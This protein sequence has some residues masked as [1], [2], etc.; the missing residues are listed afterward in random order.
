M[1]YF[2]HQNVATASEGVKSAIECEGKSCFIAGGTDLL[3]ILKDDL[4]PSYP[5]K[6]INIKTIEGLGNVEGREGGARIGALAKLSALER[7]P[8]IIEF[9]PALAESAASVATP[10][11]R[12]AATLGGN[13]CQDTRCWYYRYPHH[14]GGRMD[15]P[16]KGSGP[17]HAVLGDN[18][19]HSVIGGKR[20]FA[21]C[22]S[23]T[24][25]ALAAL[26]AT[27]EV[28]G[29]D[30][31]RSLPVEDLYSP[32]GNT[33]RGG[34]ILTNV[35][36]PAQ[37]KGSVQGFKKFTVRKPIDFAIVSVGARITALEGKVS[38]ARIFIGGVAP[39]PYRDE[40]VEN[41]LRRKPLD[42]QSIATA[43]KKALL[44]AKPLSMNAY[45][46]DIA[47]SLIAELLEE[48]TR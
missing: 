39:G 17:C 25:I 37:P 8:T 34:E 18:R 9:F 38:E 46:I 42:S 28:I 2:S 31:E 12:N 4:L 43:S 35:D 21:P 48:L 45:K 32:M 10:E 47:R 36:I 24:A 20:C 14:M 16:R 7:D 40:G 11:I 23:D 27:V 30:G 29:A 41:Y 13:L 33:L 26:G 5:E 3:G 1:R 22:P 19:Y 44:K 6:V 15:C